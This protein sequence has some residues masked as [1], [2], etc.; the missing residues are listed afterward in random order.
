MKP[1]KPYA[2]LQ[3]FALLKRKLVADAWNRANEHLD[4]YHYWIGEK[5][6]RPIWELIEDRKVKANEVLDLI[7]QKHLN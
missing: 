7:H 5:S 1:P 2:E 3:E 4:L 6:F